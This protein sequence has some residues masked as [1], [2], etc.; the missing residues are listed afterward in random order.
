MKRSCDA[1]CLPV[2]T[3]RETAHAGKS[4]TAGSCVSTPSQPVWPP[5]KK[6]V[7]TGSVSKTSPTIHMRGYCRRSA[8]LRSRMKARGM[9]WMVSWRMPSTP[10]TPSHHKE[11]CIS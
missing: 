5:M 7:C 2:K 8:A 9:Y 3:L 10:V 1:G 6:L 11:F 4:K